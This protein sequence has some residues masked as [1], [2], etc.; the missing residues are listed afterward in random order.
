M[1]K[2]FINNKAVVFIEDMNNLQVSENDR[3][4]KLISAKELFAE[5]EE[6]IKDDSKTNLYIISEKNVEKLFKIFTSFFNKIEAAGGILRNAANKIMLIYRYDKWDLPKGKMKKNEEPDN[7]AIREVMEETGISDIKII[8]KLPCTYHIYTL[9]GERIIKKTYW[10]KMFTE[11]MQTP[12]PQTEEGITDVR[13]MN[14]QEITKA[15]KNTYRSIFEL[16]RF[17]SQ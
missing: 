9:K 5:F 11:S 4:L 2:V 16:F 17:I 15:L 8:K 12:V 3:I 1:Y 6:F 14:K 7:A 10:Y 13:W